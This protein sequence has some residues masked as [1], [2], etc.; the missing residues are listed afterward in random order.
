[1]FEQVMGLYL[2]PLAVH[3]PIVLVPL[4]AVAVLTYVLVPVTRRHVAWATAI[5]AVVTPIA[6]LVAKLSG[7]ALRDDR[8]PQPPSE[9]VTH[10]EWGDR[11]VWTTFVL[12][13]V[14]LALVLVRR[15]VP[16]ASTRTWLS[17]VLS[18]LALAATALAAWFVFKVG[19]SGSEFNWQVP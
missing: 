18:A 13:P 14:A 3:V 7:E 6:A 12:G 11:L 9:I 19:H 4:L 17:W 1:M 8:Y 2:H 15:L 10:S 5:L 16:N